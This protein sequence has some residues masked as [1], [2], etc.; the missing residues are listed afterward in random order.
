MYTIDRTVVGSYDEVLERTVDSLADEGFGVMWEVDA[1]TVFEEKLG[2]SFRPYRILGACVPSLAYEGLNAEDRLGAVLPCN[3][4][5]QET[6]DGQVEVSAIDPGTLL[7][8]VDN[9]AL[10]DLVDEVTERLERVM[11]AVA[12]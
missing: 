2:K 6:D 12:S 5:V 4:V 7:A 10:D 9:P 11:D 1:P 3:V 8:I